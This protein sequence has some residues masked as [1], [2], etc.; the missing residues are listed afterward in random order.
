MK[1]FASVNT[2]P[3]VATAPAETYY[4]DR[5]TEA[6]FSWMGHEHKIM[7]AELSTERAQAGRA[8]AAAG[9]AP[10]GD[11]GENKGPAHALRLKQKGAKGPE[12]CEVEGRLKVK[13]IPV[14]ICIQYLRYMQFI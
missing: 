1:E 5:T 13:R 11:G 8:A 2:H 9:G 7:A 6:F 10:A 12:G 4:G 3:W 14:S